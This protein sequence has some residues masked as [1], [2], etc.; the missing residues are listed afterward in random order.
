MRHLIASIVL[1]A[2]P[3]IA[4][5]TV[6]TLDPMTP[7]ERAAIALLEAERT[8]ADQVSA[9]APVPFPNGITSEGRIIAQGVDVELTDPDAGYILA[10][11]DDAGKTNKWLLTILDGEVLAVQISASPEISKAKRKQKVRQLK[12]DRRALRQEAKT[13]RT[14][15]TATVNLPANFTDAETRQLVNTLRKQ[16]IDLSGLMRQVLKDS[17]D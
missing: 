1:I 6:S 5:V 8:E 4:Q 7:Q 9:L 2:A 12:Q 3:V 14:N 16:M 13:I 17:K 10:V 11:E 15:L